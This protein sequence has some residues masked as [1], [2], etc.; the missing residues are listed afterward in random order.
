MLPSDSTTSAH[1][2]LAMSASLLVTLFLGACAS[3]S[4]INGSSYKAEMAA[5]GGD[6]DKLLIVNCLL[7]GQVR[8]LGTSATYLTAR[9]PIKTSAAMCEIRGGEYVAYD[10]ANMHTALKV[11]LTAAEAGD[12]KAQ[13]YCGEI[14]EQG[15]GAEPDY[16]KAAMWY[17]KA[18]AQGS[19]RAEANL[20]HLYEEGLG[21][22]Q[23]KVK[24]L[25]LYR[26]AA[27]LSG[28][29]LA[30]TTSLSALK[31]KL[32]SSRHRAARAERTAAQLRSRLQDLQH[33]LQQQ[34][35]QRQSTESRLKEVR[36]RLVENSRSAQ[37]RA[38]SKDKKTIAELRQR[39]A[40]QVAEQ[41]RTQQ[42]A[43]LLK[44]RLT[45]QKEG[46]AALKKR[47]QDVEQQLS[48]SEQDRARLA[49]KTKQLQTRQA[50]Q[51][52]HLRQSLQS[53][54]QALQQQNQQLA[55]RNTAR[56]AKLR[57]QLAAASEHITKLEQ[58]LSTR[59][60]QQGDLVQQQA[61]LAAARRQLEQTRRELEQ[62]R[63]A[64]GARDSATI[65]RLNQ[66][67]EQ[68]NQLLSQREQQVKA[69]EQQLDSSDLELAQAQGRIKALKQE[70]DTVRAALRTRSVNTDT[71]PP[72]QS[73]TAQPTPEPLPDVDFG[74]YYALV[75][76][77]NDYPHFENLRTAV[78]DARAVANV[79]KSRYGF[80]V[81][82]LLNA[83]RAQ[84]LTALNSYRAKL[85]KDD[86]F[87]L[88]YAGHGSLDKANQRGNWLPVDAAPNNTTNWIPNG[89]IT[90]ILNVMAARHIMVIADS[91]YSG[92]L[93]RGLISST[94]ATGA[95]Q[96]LQLRW[97][98]AMVKLPSRTVL[99]SGGLQ[100]VLD[101]G[102]G[103]HSVF[104]GQLLQVLQ[105]NHRVLESPLLYE[106]VAPLVKKAAARLGV[107]QDPDYG[108]IKFAGDVGAPFFFRPSGLQVATAGS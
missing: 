87:L 102:G 70:A 24:A 16:A 104:A 57:R 10:R 90:D 65:N 89:E 88:Y 25:N 78:A 91:C 92:T 19:T 43:E 15:F 8:R 77:N 79:L 17:K 99:T 94:P 62:Q 47:L 61:D 3:T 66:Q 37:P 53:T 4:G 72:A 95:P 76:G 64:L 75:I 105:S 71:N 106:E 100:P 35:R 9:R 85:T 46:S 93:A 23:N 28:D 26:K 39:L 11:W 101:S 6:P 68:Q 74:N 40:Q 29:Q 33:Q 55:A 21:V 86:N 60:Q 58:T 67:L 42:Q 50:T 98:K 13:N 32:A 7:P 1:T 56:V 2:L 48:S 103:G 59:Q 82:V 97:L 27:G 31:S 69:L 84:I 51:V 18:A 54:Q 34:N 36:L 44:A 108:P 83:T 20:A 45:A 38:D 14:Y 80:K 12:A 5:A 63:S 30:F 73:A 52:V 22:P 96:K 49:A 81:Q 41:T 107:N